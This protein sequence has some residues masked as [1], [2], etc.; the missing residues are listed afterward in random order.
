MKNA[1]RPHRTAQLAVAAILA[2]LPAL[3]PAQAIYRIVGPDGRVTF[4]D[5]P[6]AA[7]EK[8]TGKP[9]SI[10]TTSPANI[11]GAKFCISMLLS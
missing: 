10:T 6:P 11:T 2:L 1:H 4:S 3:A 7:S 5:K 9:I 8:A